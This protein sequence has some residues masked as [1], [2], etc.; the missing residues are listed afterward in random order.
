MRVLVTGA[1]TLFGAA[2]VDRLRTDP[3][4]EH[5]LAVGLE[6]DAPL[7]ASNVT[8]RAVD[9]TRARAVHD[10]LWGAGR[11]FDIDTVVHGPLHRSARDR[12]PRVHATNVEVT[13]E[14]V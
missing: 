4:V 8:Y 11:L 12:G 2:L 1:T 5:V 10:L 14:L 9:L 7:A 13:R 3:G 6:P